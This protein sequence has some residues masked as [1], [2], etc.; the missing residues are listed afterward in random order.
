MP[1]KDANLI[2]FEVSYPVEAGTTSSV[3]RVETRSFHVGLIRYRAKDEKWEAHYRDDDWQTWTDHDE[4]AAA[5][6][7]LVLRYETENQ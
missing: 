4:L 2:D 5:H 7:A 1:D 6:S 3:S